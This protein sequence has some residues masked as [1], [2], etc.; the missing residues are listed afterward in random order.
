MCCMLHT[1]PEPAHTL[2]GLIQGVNLVEGFGMYENRKVVLSSF[3]FPRLVQDKLRN[4]QLPSLWMWE[5][6]MET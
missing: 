4:E 3:A 2:T 6:G 5:L 1:A